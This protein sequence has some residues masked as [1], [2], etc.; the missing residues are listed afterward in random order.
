MQITR[1]AL[2]PAPKKSAEEYWRACHI[3]KKRFDD[4]SGER[5][6]LEHVVYEHPKPAP[7]TPTPARNYMEQVMLASQKS[8]SSAPAPAST[9]VFGSL[10]SSSGWGLAGRGSSPPPAGSKADLAPSPAAT[11]G[12][13]VKV[14][15]AVDS[16]AS[17]SA[18]QA[19][20]IATKPSLW[21][22]V[23]RA[24]EQHARNLASA[25][26]LFQQ[27]Q[28]THT[29]TMQ[30]HEENL[31]QVNAV[32][33]QAKEAYEA[34]QV[35]V[36]VGRA[37]SAVGVKSAAPQTEPCATCG[38]PTL[39]GDGGACGDVDELL[40][41]VGRFEQNGSFE[42]PLRCLSCLTEADCFV[43]AEAVS[44]RDSCLQAFLD[45]QEEVHAEP[46]ETNLEMVRRLGV[47]TLGSV[48]KA[49]GWVPGIGNIAMALKVAEGLV[50][51]GPLALYAND[52]VDALGILT[53]LIQC[54]GEKPQNST[55]LANQA[56]DLSMG[57]YYMLLEQKN[58]RGLEPESPERE[59][60][61]CQPVDIET[62]V[63]L[64][65]MLLLATPVAYSTTAAQAQRQLRLIDGDW[66]LAHFQTGGPGGQPP[67]IIA[68][69]RVQRR[70]AI[71]VPG[72]TTPGDLVVDLKAVPQRVSL[73][74]GEGGWAHRG[75]LRSAAALVRVVGGAVEHLERCGYKVCFVG[76]SL[77]AAI[78]AISALMMRLGSE[79]T[80]VTSK[81]VEAFSFALPSC[82][83]E[84]VGKF[85]EGFVT[86]VINCDDIVPRLSLETARKLRK[87]LQG[88]RPAYRQFAQEDIASVQDVRSL[89]K[90][91][92]RLGRAQ[93]A[94]A[95]PHAHDLDD[96]QL[97][98]VR[99]EL[100][101]PS[102][103]GVAAS[104]T[105]TEL[106]TAAEVKLYPPG[107]L[108]HLYR[109]RGVRRAAWVSR[110]HPALHR[111]E[112]EQGL[113]KDHGGDAYQGGLCEA[114]MI[115]RGA[116]PSPWKPFKKASAQ[117]EC[118]HETFGWD[119]VLHSEPHRLQAQHHCHLCGFVVC[120]S[121]SRKRK[122]L[123]HLGIRHDVLVCDRCYLRPGF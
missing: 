77:G 33:R 22:V 56:T 120:H 9:S 80:C 114:V 20:G 72:T 119:T 62:L 34:S 83:D 96:E 3:C 21:G 70:A 90:Q 105:T 35:S 26:A 44:V 52:I 17:S 63:N 112:V 73:G 16:V 113:V 118:C 43:V 36:V 94:D 76:H 71:L 101:Q 14:T 116:Q 25:S 40:K 108:V 109:Y 46:E 12:P 66:S 19:T 58:M 84:K 23:E 4:E 102:S 51:Y 18:P 85:C 67:Y 81:T 2:M 74:S 41:G 69:S 50:L 78:A 13:P 103:P 106:D 104:S 6:F 88:R 27:A 55:E 68:V 91:K 110:G 111:I 42:V 15:T 123:P 97:S 24:R 45:G 39:K 79:Y 93:A 117:C 59:H 49:L 89:V 5:N 54:V 37:A 100:S 95:N 87:D 65:N 99:E 115:A 60:K 28:A 7:T 8:E 86:A 75:M 53:V 10:W 1:R 38:Y 92:R 61:N 64:S 47:L 32:M 31:L 48:N 29:Q 82:G 30:K 107:R 11:A 121:C 57:V 122:P 98:N